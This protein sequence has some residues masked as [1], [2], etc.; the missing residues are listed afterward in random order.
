M[1]GHPPRRA[2]RHPRRDCHPAGR[3]APARGPAGAGRGPCRAHTGPSRTRRPV[4]RCTPARSEPSPT[5]PRSH[6]CGCARVRSR[7]RGTAQWRRAPPG[8][9]AG[10]ET[11]VLR[12]RWAGLWRSPRHSGSPA[13]PARLA[14]T[15]AKLVRKSSVLLA[16]WRCHERS[17]G[18]WVVKGQPTAPASSRG[19]GRSHA[20]FVRSFRP[21]T[22]GKPWP[23]E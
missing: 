23:R 22:S 12:G 16:R 20:S 1:N 2:E 15:R 7:G 19:S 5:G 3:H 9:A 21:P 11:P 14:A 13:A 4:R 18:V 17:S 10:R 8:R 6:R